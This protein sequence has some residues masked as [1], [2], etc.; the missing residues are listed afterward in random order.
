M[1]SGYA[2]LERDKQ[3]VLEFITS[4]GIPAESVVFRFVNVNKETEPIYNANGN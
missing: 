2:Q 4:R 3:M 1:A